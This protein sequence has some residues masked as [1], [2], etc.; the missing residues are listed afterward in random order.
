LANL[1]P[2]VAICRIWDG[3]GWLSGGR[4]REEKKRKDKRGMLDREGGRREMEAMII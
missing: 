1:G 4:E 2:R 3:H